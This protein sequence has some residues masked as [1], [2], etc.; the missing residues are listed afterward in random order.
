MN[1]PILVTEKLSKNY[2][3][4]RALAD[5]SLTVST[6]EIV[7]LLG[8]NGSGKSTA[9]RMMLGFMQPTA[10]HVRI[11][12]FDCWSQQRRNAETRGIPPRRT[13]PLR[14]DD[15]PAA[16]Q[17]PLPTSRRVNPVRKSKSSRR[18]STSTSTARSRKCPA[19]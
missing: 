1:E 3:S 14:H 17:V 6:G 11:S 16:R 10:G 18:N 15:R 4:F 7:G 9:I 19:A 8:P 5:M 2:G 13:P 12:G